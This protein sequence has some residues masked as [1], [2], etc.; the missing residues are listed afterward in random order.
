MDRESVEN[1]LENG[2]RVQ[3][4]PFCRDMIVA[5]LKTST[6]P[7][8]L[9]EIQNVTRMSRIHCRRTLKLLVE[10]RIVAVEKE[11]RLRRWR[12]K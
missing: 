12:L 11:G 9:T 5:H 8:D 1:I 2:N 10:D 4:A 6:I 7:V 3:V